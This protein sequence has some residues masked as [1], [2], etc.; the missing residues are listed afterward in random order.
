MEG[1]DVDKFISK[2]SYQKTLLEK[3]FTNHGLLSVH[4]YLDLEK[5]Q[6]GT[7]SYVALLQFAHEHNELVINKLEKPEIWESNKYLI[8]TN[9]SVNQ[10]NLIEVQKTI[11]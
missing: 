3:I 11:R 5:K 2:I 10:L 7:I 8:L 6:F 9:D 4:E 1:K